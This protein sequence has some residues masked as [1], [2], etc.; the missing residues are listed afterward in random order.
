MLSC[1]MCFHTIRG[2]SSA[3]CWFIYLFFYLIFSPIV[4]GLSQPRCNRTATFPEPLPLLFSHL[5]CGSSHF[6]V[7]TSSAFTLT[8]DTHDKLGVEVKVMGCE[9]SAPAPTIYTVHI[10]T[11]AA[12]YTNTRILLMCTHTIS[13]TILLANHP[14]P[15]TKQVV[16]LQTRW[17]P[18]CKT[19][20]EKK[21]RIRTLTS[22]P[23][24]DS[25]ICLIYFFFSITCQTILLSLN[26]F[27]HHSFF[28]IFQ[29]ERSNWDFPHFRIIPVNVDLILAFPTWYTS[30]LALTTNII[31]KIIYRPIKI[32]ISYY[33]YSEKNE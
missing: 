23:N 14:S 29:T 16:V 25:N 32:L 4:T 24:F 2:E 22:F 31:L 9:S 21:T 20:K 3:V 7:V 17:W 5:W 28:S 15:K 1:P 10:H 33:L 26:I 18:G 30:N 11:K 13:H 12:R 6:L 19:H 8:R 27:T